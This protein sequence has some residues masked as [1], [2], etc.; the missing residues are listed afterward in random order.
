MDEKSCLSLEWGPMSPQ[1]GA[2]SVA[3][4]GDDFHIWGILQIGGWAGGQQIFIVKVGILQNSHST[5]I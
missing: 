3:D 1:H 4:G 2:S 5:N